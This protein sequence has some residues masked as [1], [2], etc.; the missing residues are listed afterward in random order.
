M[1]L[2]AL[3]Q[4]VLPVLVSPA[5]VVKRESLVFPENKEERVTKVPEVPLENRVT[6]VQLVLMVFKVLPASASVVPEVHRETKVR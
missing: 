6:L 2:V 3:V 5:H 1:L 4:L